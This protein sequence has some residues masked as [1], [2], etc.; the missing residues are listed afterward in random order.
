ML[1]GNE[2]TQVYRYTG[3]VGDS[4]W[5]HFFRNLTD[6]GDGP[7]FTGNYG[8]YAALVQGI[9]KTLTQRF[10]GTVNR[11]LVIGPA[12]GPPSPETRGKEGAT[13]VIL[14]VSHDLDPRQ[15]EAIHEALNPLMIQ[16]NLSK[17]V[18]I[19][20]FTLD[21]AANPKRLSSLKQ[22]LVSLLE[23]TD[24]RDMPS[25]L[26]KAVNLTRAG[27]YKGYDLLLKEN[28]VLLYFHEPLPQ[29]TQDDL[30]EIAQWIL[31][32]TTTCHAPIAIAV[33][34]DAQEKLPQPESQIHQADN[35]QTTIKQHENKRLEPGNS[36]PDDANLNIGNFDM[37]LMS[38]SLVS[39]VII[40][41]VFLFLAP[42]L[43]KPHNSP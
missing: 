36:Y 19:K 1:L 39:A 13:T 34:L 6:V 12:I 35:R 28:T 11:F 4:G 15:V 32:H 16:N 20:E 14:F 21:P 30:E 29:P 2:C 42:R 5:I 7:R 17:L 33:N 41:S 38:I 26:S 18:L 22:E 23:R 37:R 40:G 24:L 43:W 25:Y 31:T 3:P 10:P 8:K 27:D 9:N